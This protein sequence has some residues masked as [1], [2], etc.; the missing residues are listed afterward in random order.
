MSWFQTHKGAE[1]KSLPAS[2]PVSVTLGV[3]ALETMNSS[4]SLCL[5]A[6][7]CDSPLYVVFQKSGYIQHSRNLIVDEALKRGSTHLMFIDYDMFFPPDTL[8]RLLARDKDIVACYYN[9]RRLPL[10]S[11]TK[12]MGPNGNYVEKFEEM[13]KDIFECDATG[14]GCMLIK[15]D[16]FK[17]L[18]DPWFNVA[19][20]EKKGHSSIIGEDMWFCRNAKKHGYKIWVDPTIAIYHLGEYAY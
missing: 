19:Y 3:V 9:L 8:K 12:F 13:P 4:T 14:T 20:K 6:L 10:V 18:D 5:Y 16:V 17:H 15:M 2:D 1:Q 7:E 11:T